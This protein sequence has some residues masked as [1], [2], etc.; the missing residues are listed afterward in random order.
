MTILE[1]IELDLNESLILLYFK[2]K[3]VSLRLSFNTPSRKFYLSLIALILIETKNLKNTDF[4]YIRK[5]E[6]ELKLLDKYLAGHHKS[7]TV[8]GMWEKIRKAWRYGLP[9]L[10][11]T[12]LFS[13]LNREKLPPYEK[14]SKYRYNCSD[15]ECDIWAN[16]FQFD[17]RNIWKLKF[18]FDSAGLDLG[19]VTLKFGDLRDKSAWD[20]F[21][22]EIETSSNKSLISRKDTES[23]KTITNAVHRHWR[24]IAASFVIAVFVIAGGVAI[25]YRYTIPVTVQTNKVKE[26]KQ[27]I[28]I[29]PFVNISNDPDMDYFCDGITDEIISKL[30]KLK[31]LRVISRTSAFALKESELDIPAIAEKLSVQNILEGSVRVADNGLRVTAQLISATNDSHLW[32]ETY[33]SEMKNVFELQES[34]A[35]EIACSLKSRLGCEGGEIFLGHV[36]QNLDAYNLYL[37]GRFYFNKNAFQKAIEYFERAIEISPHYAA[38]YAGLADAF[39]LVAFYN[40]ELNN[41]YYQKAKSSV[42]KALELDEEL[43]EA[44]V[45]LARYEMHFEWDW[46][47]VEK[48][49]LH[50]IDLNPGDAEPRSLYGHYLRVVGR[51][52]EAIAQDKISLKLDPLSI[53]ANNRYGLSLMIDRQLEP[54]ILQLEST[55]QMHPDD[56]GAM[57]YLGEAYLLQNRIKEGIALIKKIYLKFKDR[58]HLIHG[59]FGQTQ[60][61]YGNSENAIK[62]LNEVLEKRKDSYFSPF[63]IAVI[64]QGLGQ[65]DKT[66]EWFQKAYDE[67]DPAMIFLS[68]Y[69]QLWDL[70]ADPRFQ[71]LLKKIGIGGN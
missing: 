36:T 68:G 33:D 19:D 25:L 8:K 13:I 70:H 6:N 63:A 29:L 26:K 28:A 46:K 37:K 34:L 35:S 16:L 38:P 23:T 11:S 21:L 45:A 12:E 65:I 55:L 44:Y 57:L 17:E 27:S 59:I 54:A 62:I 4:I 61:N 10:E 24:L 69:P 15:N 49:I 32:S 2:D 67:R 3:Q 52:D 43:P 56:L 66:F 48:A 41:V 58:S 14:G 71:A 47:G 50:A 53:V 5:Y 51:L 31:D 40:L 22:K 1:K 9:D 7:N 30:A 39:Q 20:A 42:Q 60:G 64:Y 18:A